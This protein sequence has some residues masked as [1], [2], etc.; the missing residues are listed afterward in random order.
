MPYAWCGTLGELKELVESRQHVERLTSGYELVYGIPAESQRAAWNH[1]IRALVSALD[2]PAFDRIPAIC[3]LQMPVGG[4]R[5]DHS[6]FFVDTG[7]A[8][9]VIRDLGSPTGKI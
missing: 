3:E 8:G 2:D 9:T 4:E 6:R 5:A 1:S 7:R